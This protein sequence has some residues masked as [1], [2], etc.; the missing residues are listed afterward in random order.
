MECEDIG[1]V[2]SVEPGQPLGE[3]RNDFVNRARID[4]FYDGRRGPPYRRLAGVYASTSPRQ[5]RRASALV[6]PLPLT[7]HENLQHA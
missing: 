4:K 3:H 1:G 2:L 6:N 5:M 7:A